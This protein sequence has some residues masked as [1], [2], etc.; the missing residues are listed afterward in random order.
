VRGGVLHELQAVLGERAKSI[1]VG[2]RNGGEITLRG[3]VH[4]AEEKLAVASRLR[5][6]RGCVRVTNLLEVVPLPGTAP[7]V[8]ASE[9]KPGL[10]SEKPAVPPA[11]KPPDMPAALAK[12]PGLPESWVPVHNEEEAPPDPTGAALPRVIAVADGRP[13]QPA[14]IARS[15]DRPA[16][17]SPYSMAKP[18]APAPAPSSAPAPVYHPAPPAPKGPQVLPGPLPGSGWRLT[19]PASRALAS[20]AS[21]QG[22]ADAL[23]SGASRKGTA[24]VAVGKPEHPPI[25]IGVPGAAP[26]ATGTFPPDAPGTNAA[27]ARLRH[28]LLALCAGQ[29]H[30]VQVTVGADG[31]VQITVKAKAASAERDLTTRLLALPELQRA[32]VQLMVEIGPP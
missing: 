8:L 32:N 27:A 17:A 16:P 9:G 19:G 22:T 5:R 15:S 2:T 26:V 3:E 25:A 21:R 10:P 4:S 20:G 30:D 11:A 7:A 24:D 1:E 12:G 6:V 14:A 18:E 23:A 31:R 28:K 29:A 13:Q